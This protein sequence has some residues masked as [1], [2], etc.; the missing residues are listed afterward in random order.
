M[1]R[2]WPV[3]QYIGSKIGFIVMA[4]KNEIHLE[5]GY[6]WENTEYLSV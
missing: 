5:K 3:V 1:V 6:F 4:S 2:Y